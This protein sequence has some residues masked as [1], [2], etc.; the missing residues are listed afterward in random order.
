M[1]KLFLTFA[2]ML[3]GLGS[4]SEKENKN[5]EGEKEINQIE[6]AEKL[7]ILGTYK[8]PYGAFIHIQKGKYKNPNTS[9]ENE[10]I[11]VTRQNLSM[12]DSFPCDISEQNN[13]IVF[14]TKIQDVNHLINNLLY[15]KN[16]KLYFKR[17]E[18]EGF[19]ECIKVK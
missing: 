9:E 2:L 1:K 10:V 6:L 11:Y 3:F 16:A 12:K 13:K 15:F 4:C 14:T 8:S 7:G 17:Y 5:T 18:N 19:K